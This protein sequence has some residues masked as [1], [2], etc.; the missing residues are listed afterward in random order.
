MI[1]PNAAEVLNLVGF[2]TG[3]ALY[4][5]LLALVLRRGSDKP[6]GWSPPAGG[7][8]SGNFLPL[9]TGV[10]GLI[11]NLGELAAYSLPRLGY[12]NESIGLWAISFPALGLLAAVVVHSVAQALPR[13]LVLTVVAY[14]C[15]IVASVLHLQTVI[16]GNPEPSSLAF[17]ILTICYGLIILALGVLTRTQANGQRVLWVLALALFAVSASHLG[18]FHA[19]A[20]GWAVELVGHHAAIPLAFAILYQDYRFALADLF[21]KRALTLI[22]LVAIAF[23]GYSLATQLPAGP[24]AAG[25][26]MAL[27]VATSLVSPWLHRLIV[28][29]VDHSLLGRIDYAAL[30]ASIGQGLQAR[31][32]IDGVLDMVAERLAPALDARRVWWEEQGAAGGGGPPRTTQAMVPTTDLPHYVVNVGELTGGRRLLSD[33]LALVETVVATAARRIDQVRLT[34]ERYEVQLREEEMQKLTAEAELK[35]L[36]AQVNPHFLFN[37]LTTIGYLIESAPP[38]AMNTLM[39]LTALLRGVLRSE[40]DFTTLGR[41]LELVEHYLKI[42]HERF[43]ERLRVRVDV[44]QALRHLRIPALVVQPLVENAIKH[45][46]APSTTG[47]EVQVAARLD[48][49]DGVERLHIVVRNTGAPLHPGA[50]RDLG[51]PTAA[52]GAKVGVDNVRRRLAG[53]YGA[54][55]SLTLAT[56]PGRGTV[57]ELVV[58]L[59]VA[60]ELEKDDRDAQAVAGGTGRR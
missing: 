60:A 44:P 49:V 34:H 14:G 59:A 5:M 31:N 3:T 36:R 4:A 9:A 26:L 45:G 52:P 13:G 8:S 38:R 7:A 54:S 58:P 23:A 27:W 21:L 57:A 12:F 29:F 1:A 11:W 53:H 51:R 6:K 10:L 18:R 42:E 46:V 40:G 16:T 24:L 43:E 19:A 37:A 35:A 2:V 17:L 55:A 50:L 41:E 22:A 56:E 30:A 28:R 25:V 15:S 20:D 32:T 33:D 39:Q 48:A 47:G